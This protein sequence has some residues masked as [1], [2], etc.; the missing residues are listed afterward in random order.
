M[1]HTSP[2]PMTKDAKKAVE[3]TVSKLRPRLGVVRMLS[4]S[5]FAIEDAPSATPAERILNRLD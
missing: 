5:P 1:L 4:A 3:I 2:A